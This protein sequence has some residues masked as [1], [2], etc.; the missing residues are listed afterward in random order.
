MPLSLPRLRGRRALLSAAAVLVALG[1]LLW[2]LLPMGPPSPKGTVRFSTGIDTGV[3]QLYGKRLQAAAARDLPDVT[4]RLMNSD[5]SQENVARVATGRADFTIA[6]ADAVEK[7]IQEGGPG[8]DRLRGCVRLYDDYIHLVVRA[9][10]AIDSI[11]D[12]R[13]ATVGVG[14]ED[15]GVRLIAEQVLR[16]AGLDLYEDVDP[17]SYGIDTVDD[18]LEAGSIDAFFWSGGLPT[19]AITELSKRTD[20]RLVPL[21]DLVDALHR[22]GGVARY[23]RSA[24]MPETAYARAQNGRP[25]TTL[26]VANLLVTTDRADRGLTEALTRAVIDSR[27]TIGKAVH[28]AQLVDVRTALYTDP[29]ELHDGARRY[30]RSVKP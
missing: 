19:N 20:I 7:Y 12:L 8:G 4:M 6:A 25:V 5:G 28:A 2:W 18:R 9:D 15:S 13:G 14:P 27:D 10:S 16:A 26:A 30:Y 3:Y 1:L 29:L 22:M 24:V 21:G 23:Y 17:T 11:D